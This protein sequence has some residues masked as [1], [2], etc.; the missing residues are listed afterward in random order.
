MPLTSR[1][2]EAAEPAQEVHRPE[3][4]WF[5]RVIFCGL[6]LT[7]L[8]LLFVARTLEPNPDGLGTHRQLLDLPPC[9]FVDFFGVPCPSCGM[10]TSWAH[11]TRGQLVH[12]FHANA[13]GAILALVSIPIGAWLLVSGCAGRWWI[14]K[15]NH[16]K[17]AFVL[18]L[19]IAVALAQWAMR[20]G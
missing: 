8:G 3:L 12:A 7:M 14:T 4:A 10:T 1:Q 15:P 2:Q 9:G 6:G 16:A 11:V 13:G 19:V 20:F 18:A 5:L 17:L